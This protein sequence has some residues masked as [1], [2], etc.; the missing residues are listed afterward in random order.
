MHRIFYFSV[1]NCK[2]LR[3]PHFYQLLKSLKVTSHRGY[4]LLSSQLSPAKNKGQFCSLIL[5]LWIQ[6]SCKYGGNPQNNPS[7]FFPAQYLYKGSVSSSLWYFCESEDA[8]AE[9]FRIFLAAKTKTLSNCDPAA[10]T[11]KLSRFPGNP[12]F[13]LKWVKSKH[14]LSS[15]WDWE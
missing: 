9:W 11:E 8:P 3:R 10:K 5:C 1:K 13:G 7:P 14:I 15:S 12:S 6:L 4:L 2:Q